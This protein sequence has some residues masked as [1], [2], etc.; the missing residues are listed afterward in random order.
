M[1]NTGARLK[2]EA[3]REVA[4]GDITASFV[5]MGATFAGPLRLLYVGND[6]NKDVYLSLDGTNDHFKVKANGFRLLDL[7]TNDSFVDA[8]QGIYLRG[9]SGDL[10]TSG[11]VWVEAMFT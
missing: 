7:K 9:I 11:G 3:I 1:A 2:P 8:G 6:S 4:F 10:P 5:Q